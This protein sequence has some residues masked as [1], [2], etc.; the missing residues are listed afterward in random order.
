MILRLE[1]VQHV[2]PER[3]RRLHNVRARRIGFP[4]DRKGR[5]RTMHDDAIPDECVHELRRGREVRLIGRQ[6]EPARITRLGFAQKCL[7]LF[8]GRAASTAA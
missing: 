4:R 3:L 7:E 6:N 5:G 2:W 8:D 1:H